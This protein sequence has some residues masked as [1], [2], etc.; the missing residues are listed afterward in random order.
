MA[1]END[2][3]MPTIKSANNSQITEATAAADDDAT[4]VIA[5]KQTIDHQCS[6]DELIE[7]L[8]D[9]V[10]ESSSLIE[11]CN[12]LYV[13][14]EKRINVLSASIDLLKSSDHSNINED[15][16]VATA[17]ALLEEQKLANFNEQEQLYETIIYLQNGKCEFLKEIQKKKC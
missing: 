15:L 6:N 5:L 16:L 4:T 3:N 10:E 13:K 1:I 12:D 7:S 14:Y 11:F 8:Y 2:K 17:A 9:A